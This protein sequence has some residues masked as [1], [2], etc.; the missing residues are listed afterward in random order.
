MI[1]QELTD[2]HRPWEH[3]EGGGA[4]TIDMARLLLHAY[5]LGDSIN[6]SAEVAEYLYWKQ[7]VDNDAE[8]AALKQKFRKAKETFAECERFGRFHPDYHAAKDA[9]KA[10]QRQMDEHECVKRFKEA[11]RAVDTMLHDIAQLIA[12]SVSDTIK[13]PGND[14]LPSG[15]CGSG[16]SCSCGSGGCG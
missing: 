5:E 12:G 13:V 2:Y 9:V 10:V 8:V 4:E 7:E 3:A 6:Q 1:E 16:G 14:P 11:E 15:G